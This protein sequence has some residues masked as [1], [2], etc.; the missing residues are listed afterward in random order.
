MRV[1]AVR[2][3]SSWRSRMRTS[4]VWRASIAAHHMTMIPSARLTWAICSAMPG[5]D[6]NQSMTMNTV[7]TLATS[8]G[9]HGL[10]TRKHSISG[11]R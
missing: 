4:R 8:A 10:E 3:Q 11:I 6:M 1:R 9:S 5:A 2:I 7:Q